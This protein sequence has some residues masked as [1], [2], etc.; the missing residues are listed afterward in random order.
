MTGY[1]VL[2][3]PIA[4]IY[5]RFNYKN[6][7]ITSESYNEAYNE[8]NHLTELLKELNVGNMVQLW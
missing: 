5:D 1:G 7:I 6:K 4:K 2:E 3:K 8:A